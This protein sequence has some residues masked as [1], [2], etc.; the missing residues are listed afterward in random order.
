MKT[1]RKDRRLVLEAA[2]VPTSQNY[3]TARRQ[4][5]RLVLT[6]ASPIPESKSLE[7]VFETDEEVEIEFSPDNE[8]EEPTIEEEEENDDKGIVLEM[9]STRVHPK[10]Q[11]TGEMNVHRSALMANKFIGLT[12][13]MNTTISPP[14]LAAGEAPPGVSTLPQQTFAAAVTEDSFN[15]YKYCWRKET[16]SMVSVGGIYHSLDQ[17]YTKDTYYYYYNNNMNNLLTSKNNY[18]I[19]NNS[20]DLFVKDS[21]TATIRGNDYEEKQNSNGARVVEHLIVPVYCKQEPRRSLDFQ[22]SD[23]YKNNIVAIHV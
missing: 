3:F 18:N 14:S 19:N 4:D 5:G 10:L 16:P 23:R 22:P 7:D 12:N 8:I 13:S 9:T 6:F 11:P 2:S 15:M 1:H 20:N 17:Q 21:I